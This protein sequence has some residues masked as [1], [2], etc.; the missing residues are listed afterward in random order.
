MCRGNE[1]REEVRY[2]GTSGTR[3]SQLAPMI[4]LKGF[5]DDALA[6]SAG[7]FFQNRIA[8]RLY[9]IRCS[10]VLVDDIL[11]DSCFSALLLFII[12]SRQLHESH[13]WHY[14]P[15]FR[16]Q[17]RGGGVARTHVN[18]IHRERAFTHILYSAA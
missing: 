12:N 4:V 2:M 6:I 9:C 18:A 15:C 16:F 17:M 7:R 14:G 8:R 10:I 5:I 11:L 3:D 13:N 1:L